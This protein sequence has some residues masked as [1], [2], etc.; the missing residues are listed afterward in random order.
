MEIMNE[1]N[2]FAKNYYKQY[3]DLCKLLDKCLHTKIIND[4]SYSICLD[5]DWIIRLN[6]DYS[7]EYLTEIWSGRGG[8]YYN[9]EEINLYC[10]LD[11]SRNIIE[12]ELSQKFLNNFQN[13][14]TGILDK[15]II[16][17]PDSNFINDTYF[18]KISIL[19]R[20]CKLIGTYLLSDEN[21]HVIYIRKESETIYISDKINLNSILK[22]GKELW[23][24]EIEEKS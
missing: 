3:L 14:F 7:N 16:Q 12:K 8:D 11:F 18:N 19:P 20:N 15:M 24:K 9:Y 2:N 17:N 4:N 13:E 1:F 10:L 21:I 22:I 5:N 6:L 23:E